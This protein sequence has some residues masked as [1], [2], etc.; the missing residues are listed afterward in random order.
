MFITFTTVV[1][2]EKEREK[3]MREWSLSKVLVK[4]FDESLSKK[5]K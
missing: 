2:N 5:N 4:T 3:E 1:K